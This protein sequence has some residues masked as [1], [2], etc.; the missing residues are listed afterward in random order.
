M[1][2]RIFQDENNTYIIR[3]ITREQYYDYKIG[4]CIDYPREEE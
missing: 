1:K 4:T 2:N 3:F